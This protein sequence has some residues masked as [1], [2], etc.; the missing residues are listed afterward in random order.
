M[1]DTMNES[2][3]IHC[4]SH[5]LDLLKQTFVKTIQNQ[6]K[7]RASWKQRMDIYCKNLIYVLLCVRLECT[8]LRLYLSWFSLFVYLLYVIMIIINILG[9]CLYSSQHFYHPYYLASRRLE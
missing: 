9:F 8:V 7:I 5:G 4:V 3:V 6:T 1:L 2:H